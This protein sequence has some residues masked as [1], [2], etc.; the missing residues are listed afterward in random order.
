MSKMCDFP[1]DSE[2]I[3]EAT[4]AVTKGTP[5]AYLVPFL[6]RVVEHQKTEIETL[7][8]LPNETRAT[9]EAYKEFADMIIDTYCRTDILPAHSIIYVTPRELKRFVANLV[10]ERV[11]NY[12]ESVE[13]G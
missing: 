3:K 1:T 10:D 9:L 11:A 6:L 5:C 8:K 4:D 13:T 2:I 12:N 7:K